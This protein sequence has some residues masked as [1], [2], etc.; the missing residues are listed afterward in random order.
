MIPVCT[1][2][3][4]TV[5]PVWALWQRR[6][7]DVM[8]DAGIA[9]VERYTRDDGTLIWR[10]EWP[11][12]DGSDDA[13]ESFYT[14]PLFY[15]LGGSERYRDLARKHFEAVTWQ[16]TEYGQV[17]REFDAYYDWMHHGESSLYF[18]FLGLS[19]PYTLRDRQRAARFAEFYTGE[20]PEAPNYDPE[21]R[22]IRS[23]INGSRGPRLEMTAED[24]STHRWV[25]SHPM[26][27]VPFEDIPGVPGPSADWLDDDVFTRILAAMNQRMARGDVPINLLATT[28]VTHAFLYTGD[29]KYQDWVLEYLDAWKTRAAD[30]GGLLPDNVGLSGKIGECMDGKWWGGYYGWRWPHGGTVLLES[31]AV[32]GMNAA[33]LTGDL[34]HLDLARAQLDGLWE[35]RQEVEGESR[36]PLRHTDAG[37]TDFRRMS[38][39]LPIQLWQLSGDDEDLDRVLRLPG[40]ET[41]CDDLG[42]R[43]RGNGAAWFQFVRG[44][45]EDFPEQLLQAEYAAVCQALDAIRNDHEPAEDI[46]IQHWIGRNPVLCGALLQLTTGAPSPIY[47]GGLIHARV[48]YYDAT[49]E[50]PGLPT[51]VAALV[52]RVSDS[53]FRVQLVNLDPQRSKSVILQAGAFGEHDFDHVRMDDDADGIDI[54][55][56][57]LQVNLA[58]AAGTVLDLTVRRFVRSP[59]YDT[60]WQKQADASHIQLRD[61]SDNSRNVIFEWEPDHPRRRKQDDGS[62]RPPATGGADGGR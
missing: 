51:D 62:S 61:P 4:T 32:A 23:P 24:W 30:N 44:E 26:F 20:D 3:S 28:L 39:A 59:S 49:A 6:L 19:E 47:H 11:G 37:W 31:A 34:A 54:G 36:V 5:P 46:Y 43:G 35:L 41:W 17:H 56:Q 13:Y 14:F 25:L 42:V 8:D 29:N 9:Y 45:F 60:P 55:G 18:Y 10:H 33:L 40:Q 50:R 7:I 58:P 1:A 22:L 38:P 52:D 57:W 16:W 2:D 21:H 53:G 12:M 15:A 48:R 27:G